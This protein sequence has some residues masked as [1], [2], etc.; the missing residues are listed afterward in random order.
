M[1]ILMKNL[2]RNGA[3][4]N[5]QAQEASNA[6]Y[7]RI[8]TPVKKNKSKHK[9]FTDDGKTREATQ[10][11]FRDEDSGKDVDI[12]LTEDA[13]KQNFNTKFASTNVTSEAELAENLVTST[14]VV[15]LP[16]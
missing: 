1:Q 2:I 11:I 9:H 10:N 12:G 16:Q 14:P 13:F 4:G 7:K 3:T 8:T 15:G 5:G 6:S